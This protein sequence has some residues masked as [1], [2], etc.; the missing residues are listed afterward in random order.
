MN[1]K[2]VSGRSIRLVAAVPAVL[3]VFWVGVGCSGERRVDY[4]L[5]E[6][7][8]DATEPA[9][10]ACL[11]GETE[12]FVYRFPAGNGAKLTASVEPAF[13]VELGG[14][15][16][17]RLTK[18][19]PLG[20]EGIEVVVAE[21]TGPGQGFRDAEEHRR[22]FQACDLLVVVGGQPVGVA[23]GGTGNWEGFLPAGAFDSYESAE[24][25]YAGAAGRMERTVPAQTD[26]ERQFKLAD[27]WDQLGVRGVR[28]SPDLMS[29]LKEQDPAMYQELMKEPASDCGDLPPF[30]RTD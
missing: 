8:I 19:P 12:A 21:V 11:N 25:V 26:L 13:S 10:S 18:V 3:A 20:R 16:G 24:A 29:A 1:M 17:V 6:P 14:D 30:P 15:A 23:Y 9:S 7:R 22:H 5:M 2:R 4:H 27:W 28:C